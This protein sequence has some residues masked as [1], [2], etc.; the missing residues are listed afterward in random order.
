VEWP[1]QSSG[2]ENVLFSLSAAYSSN[3]EASRRLPALPIT[4]SV[5]N[6]LFYSIHHAWYD[7]TIWILEGHSESANLCHH[8]C[9]FF[10]RVRQVTALN[11]GRFSISGSGKKFFKFI[12]WIQTLT[13]ITT[14]VKTPLMWYK[15]WLLCN[16]YA[17]ILLTNQ[18]NYTIRN[19]VFFQAFCDIYCLALLA[20]MCMFCVDL[21]FAVVDRNG[22]YIWLWF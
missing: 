2:V 6:I 11:S 21:L 19:N 7:G 3:T 1:R 22:L 5:Y 18:H 17:I 12:I 4:M 15:S 20:F 8:R 13:R 16:L 10:R 14:K 9:H